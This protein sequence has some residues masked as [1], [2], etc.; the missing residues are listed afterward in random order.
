VTDP[1]TLSTWDEF[2]RFHREDFER[3]ARELVERT[4]S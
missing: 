3:R 4:G 2:D 1:R